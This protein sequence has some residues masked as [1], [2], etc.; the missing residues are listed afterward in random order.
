M[1]A[2]DV[3]GR[4]AAP[5][6]GYLRIA[7]IG[8]NTAG[9]AKTQIADLQ[10]KGATKLIVDVRRTSTGE[11]EEGLALARLFVAPGARWRSAK[12][13]AASRDDCRRGG[14]RR[15]S[16]CR[17]LVLV[18]TGTSG[19]RSSLRR[20][21][22]ATSA[23]TSSASTHRPRRDPAADQAARRQR[24]V[25]LDHALPHAGRHAAARKGT[26]ADGRRRRTGRRVRPAAAARRSDPR[27]GP[28]AAL[29]E[30][31]RVKVSTRTV[32]LATLNPEPIRLLY[33]PFA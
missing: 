20:R 30:E 28:R 8:P 24:P 17:S 9:Q 12:R 5:G 15:R 11:A 27:Q 10:A 25:A 6:V 19:A 31:G 4:I 22:P 32:N 16:R 7:A 23:P 1:P 14:R 26:R 29:G 2:S 21:C 33:C 18:D 3:R 13:A